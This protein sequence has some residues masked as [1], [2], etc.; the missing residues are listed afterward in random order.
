MSQEDYALLLQDVEGFKKESQQ[1]KPV[2]VKKSSL[3]IHLNPS[4]VNGMKKNYECVVNYQVDH[5]EK[6]LR[7]DSSV[8]N[9]ELVYVDSN[10]LFYLSKRQRDLLLGV[11]NP[12]NRLEVLG[13]LE[14]VESLRKGSKVYVTI[15]T[16]TAPVRGIVRYIGSLPG[17][18]GR[19]F[20]VELMGVCIHI[21]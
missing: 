19:K 15:P 2:T 8:K 3:L 11:K 13:R 4:V 14:W 1:L 20:G 9:T 18:E 6:A 16:I 10:V 7:E 21:I 17:E 5:L 12:Y